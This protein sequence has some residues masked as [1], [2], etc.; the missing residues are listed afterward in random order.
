LG[1]AAEA[2]LV[3]AARAGDR[4]AL[5]QL[6]GTYLPLVYNVVGRALHGHAD[7]DDVVQETMLRVVRRLPELRDPESF[8]S[9]VMAIAIRQ[10]QDRA[11]T[12]GAAQP[13]Y[14]P[15]EAAQDAADPADDF[16]DEAADRLSM[17]A[18]REDLLAAAHWL[19]ADERRVLS[20]WWQELYGRLTR[21][22]IAEALAVSPQHAAVRIQRMKEKLALA[23]TVVRAWRAAPRCPHLASAAPGWNGRADARVF[24]LLSRH[25]RGCPTCS[26]AGAV[27]DPIERQL[28]GAGTLSYPAQL[29]QQILAGTAA[30]AAGAGAGAAVAAAVSSG[31]AVPLAGAGAKHLLG[32]A[33]AKTGALLA[34]VLVASGV[35]ATVLITAPP[36]GPDRAAP[37]PAPSAS[38]PSAPAPAPTPGGAIPSGS[39]AASAPASIGV[40]APAPVLEPASAAV[41]LAPNGDD[42][43]DGSMAK[44]FAT[45]AKAVSVVKPGQTIYVRGGTYKPTRPVDITT[46]GTSGQPITLTAYNGERPVFDAGAAPAG[47]AFIIQTA[48][49]WTVRGLEIINARHLPYVCESCSHDTFQSLAV[50]GNRGTG[51]T[52]RGDGTVGNQVLDSDFYDNHDDAGQSADGL[53]IVFGSGAGNVVRGCRTY[54]NVDDGVKIGQ[55]A[56]PVAIDAT[57]SYGNGVNRWNLPAFSG[58]GDGFSLGAADAAPSVAH[59]IT[60]SAAWKN[61]GY[62]FTESGNKGAIELDNNTAFRN[63][64]DGFAFYYSPSKLRGNLALGNSRQAVLAAG[65]KAS[66]NS[67]NQSGWND[68]ALRDIDPASAEGPRR[69]DDTLP[70]TTYLTNTRDPGV[71]APM[72]VS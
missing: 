42:T 69:P 33:S 40:T 14:L 11:R 55:F 1:S 15:I 28:V 46:S 2:S 19:S 62:G 10:I 9:W 44:P 47:R 3:E 17:A 61:G 65:A 23:L 29:L 20:L 34:S 53:A 64:K 70:A 41:F 59:V 31:S 32:W 37:A 58:A 24:R 38:G 68:A 51:L 56:D 72:S 63:V 26:A 18:Q 48:G 54:D 25:V 57:W 16:A 5:E 21:G 22:Q 43:G 7:V 45:L 13:R 4:D 66:G 39:P 52:L 35:A 27:L 8:R 60:R 6:L 30:A 49:H 12:T 50:H 71:G 36:G 67:W